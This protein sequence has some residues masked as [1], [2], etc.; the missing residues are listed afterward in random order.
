MTF[1]G[2]LAGT[3]TTLTA[4]ID[5]ATV[6]SPPVTVTVTP[7]DVSTQKSVFRA[8][9]ATIA[10]GD[11]VELR[12]EAHDAAGNRI[13]SGGRTVLFVIAGDDPGGV[14]GPTSDR[15]DGTYVARYTGT[16]AG[17]TDTISAR[18][19]G[20]PILQKVTVGMSP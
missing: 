4:T 10:A 11:S 12:L 14:V 16:R 15:G 7:G 5:G 6:T 17:A 19:D 18:I 3:T 8:S 20:T 1:I 2:Q 13:T 9:R